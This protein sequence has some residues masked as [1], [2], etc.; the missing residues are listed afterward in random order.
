MKHETS[1]FDTLRGEHVAVLCSERAM[2]RKVECSACAGLMCDRK[3]S[4]RARVRCGGDQ[5]VVGGLHLLHDQRDQTTGIESAILRKSEPGW[6]AQDPSGRERIPFSKHSSGQRS[7]DANPLLT[8][9]SFSAGSNVQSHYAKRGGNNGQPQPAGC[10]LPPSL[11]NG[12]P[13]W[14]HARSKCSSSPATRI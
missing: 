3:G 6:R 1:T 8:A 7:I 11:A 13:G 14:L 2:L 5:S 9:E 4:R 10:A 12:S